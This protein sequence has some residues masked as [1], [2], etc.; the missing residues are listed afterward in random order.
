MSLLPNPW[1]YATGGVSIVLV[2][3]V[4]VAGINIRSAGRQIDTLLDRIENPKTGYI[5]RLATE[6]ASTATLRASIEVQNGAIE[7][8]SKESEAALAAANRKLALEAKARRVAENRAA[9]LLGRRPV[10]S[11]LEA[12]IIDV[13]NRVLETLK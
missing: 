8:M 1:K 12:R 3:V 2:L 5:A 9:V 6:E 11:T 13:D 7:T 4:I 10:G